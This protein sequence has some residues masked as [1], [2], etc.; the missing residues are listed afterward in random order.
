MGNVYDSQV[1]RRLVRYL[2][3]VRSDLTPGALGM[4]IRSVSTVALPVLVGMATDALIGNG[5]PATLN[6]VVLFVV[7]VVALGW[8]GRYLEELFLGY[9]GQKILYRVRTEMFDHLQRLSLRFFDQNKVGRIMS[10]VQSDVHQIQELLASGMLN[11]VFSVVTLV[12]IACIMLIM[13]TRLALLTLTVVPALAIVA[14]IWQKYARQAF[15]K[16][17]RAI[18]T[19]NAQL[20]EGIAGVRVT[21]SL[22]REELNSEQFEHVNREHYS[23]NIRAARLQA[24]MWPMVEIL[25]ALGT[26]LVIY[27][28]GRQ[29][30]AG[31][32]TAG[33]LV[34]FMLYVRRFFE[35]VLELT[36]EYVEIQRAM[37]SGARIF[38]LLDV[39]PEIRDASR[40]VDLPPAK[41][42]RFKGVSFGYTPGAEVLHNI[43]L[44]VHPGET[45]AIVGRTG[46]GK[47][48]LANLIT[49]FYEVGKGEVTVDG[50]NVNSVT[51]QSL[52]QQIGVVT[53]DPFLFSGTIED[54][55]RYGHLEASREEVIEAAKTARAHDFISRLQRGYETQVGERGEN[56]SAGQRQLVC[57]ARGMLANPPILVLD[58]ATSN[59]DT[60]AERLMQKSLRRLMK[61]RTCIIIAHRLSTVTNADRIVVLEQGRI[62]ETGTHKEL[63]AKKGLYYDMFG[64]LSA[65]DLEA[66]G[67]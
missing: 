24:A 65:P 15:I 61:G 5:G 53:Q 60:N 46:A 36:M 3:P 45:V 20:Q 31:E 16:V 57:L 51:Q 19:V 8:G 55:I 12:A 23:A 9:V 18:A 58:E 40:A 41:E 6:I 29:V 59:V 49:R 39:E 1:I 13:N 27:F 63:L 43:N 64:A 26:A 22:T 14:F 4:I 30:L 11:V 21:Q 32:M 37:A 17:R 44:T 50:Y 28:G 33:V 10:R 7:G 52:R 38:E 2:R 42:I 34:A 62:I 47:S 56:L 48:S 54:N 35:P 66:H 25:T 67:A